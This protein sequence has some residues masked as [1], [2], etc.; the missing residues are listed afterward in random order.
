MTRVRLE[1]ELCDQSRL[2]NDTFALSAT[3]LPTRCSK[4]ASKGP[5]NIRGGVLEDVL[6]LEDTF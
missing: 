1:I 6:G 2:K 5:I 4:N 3:L